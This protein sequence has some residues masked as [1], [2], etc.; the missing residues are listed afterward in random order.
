MEVSVVVYLHQYYQVELLVVVE[1]PLNYR[2][3]KCSFSGGGSII[4]GRGELSSSGYL[5]Q[6]KDTISGSSQ[7]PSGSRQLVGHYKLPS[8]LISGSTQI[9]ESGFCEFIHN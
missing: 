8:G 9:S 5:Q 4:S 6:V 2:F 7:L 1:Y 3:N